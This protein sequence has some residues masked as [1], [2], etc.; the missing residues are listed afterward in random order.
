MLNIDNKAVITNMYRGYKGTTG[1]IVHKSSAQA[2]TKLDNGGEDFRS[3][4]VNLKKE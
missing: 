1:T 4:K 2:Y 3:Y